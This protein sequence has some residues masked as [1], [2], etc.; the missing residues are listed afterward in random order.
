MEVQI[1]ASA[2]VSEG[3]RVAGVSDLCLGRCQGARARVCL[4]AS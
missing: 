1:G 4:N 2:D 3:A